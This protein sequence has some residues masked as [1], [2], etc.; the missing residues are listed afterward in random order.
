MARRAVARATCAAGARRDR[1]SRESVICSPSLNARSGSF[2]RLDIGHLTTRH[3]ASM[4]DL[5]PNDPLVLT[6][7]RSQRLASSIRDR[8][9]VEVY[10]KETGSG[11]VREMLVYTR[12]VFERAGAQLRER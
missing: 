1:L 5:V 6:R 3:V 2:C 7:S 4:A 8:M 12:V 11:L 10:P 9:P